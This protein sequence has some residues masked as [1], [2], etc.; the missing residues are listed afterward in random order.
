[1]QRFT[2]SIMQSTPSIEYE[3]K[4]STSLFH[5]LSCPVVVWAVWIIFAFHCLRISHLGTARQ[6][7]L[8]TLVSLSNK[9][10]LINGKLQHPWRVIVLAVSERKLV[11]GAREEENRI[12]LFT[13]SYLR[14]G[15]KERE[16]KARSHWV[17]KWLTEANKKFGSGSR[18]GRKKYNNIK[19]EIY[20]KQKFTSSFWDFG[21]YIVSW[22]FVVVV[23]FGLKSA[24][25]C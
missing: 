16:E 8:P 6:T 5:P 25:K 2:T 13:I 1:M 11:K 18:R 20:T 14:E 7:W 24:R 12:F 3:N 15:K 21:V 4:L 17:T 10:K 19:N 9:V 23:L 22:D